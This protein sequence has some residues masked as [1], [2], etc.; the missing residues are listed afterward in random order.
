M[1]SF[2]FKSLGGLGLLAA[3]SILPGSARAQDRTDALRFSQLQPQGTARSLGFGSALGSVGGDFSSLSVNP[4]GIGIYRRGE[5]TFTPSFRINGSESSFQGSTASDDIFRFNI[6]NF[7]IVST[8]APKGRRY[9][10]AAWKS[11]SFGIGVTRLADFSRAYT[12][13]GRNDSSSA[14]EAFAIAANSE[15]QTNGGLSPDGLADAAFQSFLVDFGTSV[16]QFFT[17]VDWSRGLTQG[18]T[19]RERGGISEVVFSVGGNYKE[20]L[21]LGATLGLPILR[22]RREATFTESDATGTQDSFENFSLREEL[23]TSGMGVNLKLGAIY[24]F[25]DAFRAGL[26]IHTPTAFSLRDEFGQTLRANTQAYGGVA[27]TVFPVSPFEYQL[28][29]P[30]RAV[31]SA[32]AIIG[33][34]GFVSLDYEYVD[35]ASARFQFNTSTNEALTGVADPYAELETSVNDGIRNNYQGA[36]NIRAGGEVRLEGL[37]LRAG[38]GYYGSPYREDEG[39]NPARLDVSAGIGF[40]WENIF[41]DVAYVHSRF[42]LPERPYTLDYGPSLIVETPLATVS[43]RLNNV[44]VTLGLKF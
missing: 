12:Y 42:D 39:T 21:M 22:Y 11:V 8:S 35:Y 24:R 4:A 43:N 40:R 14:T 34:V 37:N 26:A 27:E 36:S 2:R 6:S 17:N 41:L 38:L 9:D 29:T 32:T 15:F 44:A 28:V 19:V 31:A 10:R 7:G 13:S 3:W 25:S 1:Q 30:W 5:V 18:R 23:R 20:R 33:Q 16:N